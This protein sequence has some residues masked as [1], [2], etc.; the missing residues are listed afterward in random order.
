MVAVAVGVD[1]AMSVPVAIEVAVGVGVGVEVEGPPAEVT[2]AAALIR[3]NVQN[4][5]VP[6]ILSAVPVIRSTT[7][8]LLV[9]NSVAQT[10][11]AR[12]AT[13]GVACDVPDCVS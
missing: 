13:C 4:V 3:P 8:W 5:P 1:V 9:P 11:A 10:S 6:A 12:P 7:A 2:A